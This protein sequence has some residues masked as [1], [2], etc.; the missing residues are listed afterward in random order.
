[1]VYGGLVLGIEHGV[2]HLR[3]MFSSVVHLSDLLGVTQI[4]LLLLQVVFDDGRLGNLLLVGAKCAENHH[5]GDLS[6]EI[7]SVAAQPPLDSDR[8]DSR[9]ALITH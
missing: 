8:P 7:G 1:M 5:E 6:D 4:V 3:A 9:T 2:R